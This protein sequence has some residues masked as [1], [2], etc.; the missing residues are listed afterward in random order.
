MSSPVIGDRR[1]LA[2]VGAH[3]AEAPS[4]GSV[5]VRIVLPSATH[6]E[7]VGQAT[8]APEK[9]VFNCATRL[10]LQIARAAPGF[11]DVRT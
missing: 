9:S 3:L 4:A 10:R 6:S 7:V 5:D 11:V 2:L 8:A 1:Y